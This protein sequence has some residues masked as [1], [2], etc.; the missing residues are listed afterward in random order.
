MYST[1]LFRVI[2]QR[3][4]AISYRRFGTAYRSHHSNMCNVNVRLKVQLDVHGFI[5]I[6]YS[7]IFLLYVFRVLFAPI[8]RST[9]VEYSLRCV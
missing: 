5:C 1:A 7:S 2:S 3:V 9:N 6:L 4:V 8:L